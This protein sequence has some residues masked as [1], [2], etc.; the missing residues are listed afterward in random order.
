MFIGA[1]HGTLSGVPFC[2]RVD[3]V[4]SIAGRAG[5]RNLLTGRDFPVLLADIWGFFTS[6]GKRWY[7]SGYIHA[8]TFPPD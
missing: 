3:S 4:S 1:S 7:P 2:C 5:L 6:P 8:P